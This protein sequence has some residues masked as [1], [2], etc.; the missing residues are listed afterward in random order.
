MLLNSFEGDIIRF[1]VFVEEIECII[2]H[3]KQIR[4]EKEI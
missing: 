4:F 2:L 3:Q 1:D